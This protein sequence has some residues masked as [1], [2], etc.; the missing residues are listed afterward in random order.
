MRGPLCELPPSSDVG[1]RATFP[2]T[3]PLSFREGPLAQSVEQRTSGKER[4]SGNRWSV[5]SC[6]LEPP[7]SPR[8]RIR[9]DNPRGLGNQQA[10]Q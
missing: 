10:T 7:E 8:Y 1:S 9:G 5:G 3:A 6:L 2:V 4:Q